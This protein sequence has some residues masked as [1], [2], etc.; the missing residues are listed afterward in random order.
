MQ[1][2]LGG[3]VSSKNDVLRTPSPSRF[4]KKHAVQHIPVGC[5]QPS[6]HFPVND[7]FRHLVSSFHFGVCMNHKSVSRDLRS[8]ISNSFFNATHS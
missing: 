6:S 4:R 8:T 5:V 3:R 1:F 2:L 7:R